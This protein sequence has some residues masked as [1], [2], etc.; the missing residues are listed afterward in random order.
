MTNVTELPERGIVLDLDA[1]E[2]PQDQ[3]KPPFIVK[4]GGKTITFLDPGEID[5]RDLASVA[6]P[7]DLI[8]VSLDSAD[9]D[10]IRAQALPTWKFNKLMED[11]YTH[12][13]MEARIREAKR[14]ASFNGI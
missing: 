14:Q 12:Y 13:D 7:S 4:V 10:H 5:W 11:Y 6:A 9:L 1:E 2:R 3:I 8:R